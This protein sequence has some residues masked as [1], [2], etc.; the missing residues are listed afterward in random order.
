MNFFY[1]RE[2]RKHNGRSLK[3]HQS[4]RRVARAATGSVK[5]DDPMLS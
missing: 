1:L 3:E 4:Q 2:V 5:Q